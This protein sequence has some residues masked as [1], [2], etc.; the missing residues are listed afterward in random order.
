MSH[1]P[2]GLQAALLAWG[3]ANRRDLPWRRTRDGWAVLVSELMEY[4]YTA[5]ERLMEQSVSAR[6][7]ARIIPLFQQAARRTAR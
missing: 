3:E 4:L 2:A 5:Q 7:P 1:R 6:Q